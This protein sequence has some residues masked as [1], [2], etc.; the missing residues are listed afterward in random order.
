MD[1]GIYTAFCQVMIVSVPTLVRPIHHYP[2]IQAADH[3]A[4]FTVMFL[5]IQHHIFQH[6]ITTAGI[7]HVAGQILMYP[8][9]SGQYHAIIT[10]LLHGG[11]RTTGHQTGGD[12]AAVQDIID[13]LFH[14]RSVPGE[15]CKGSGGKAAIT[16]IKALFPFH[17]VHQALLGTVMQR[18]H[19]QV[20]NGL[21]SRILHLA[22][23]LEG[24]GIV[25][26]NHGNL[27]QLRPFRT[28]DFCITEGFVIKVIQRVFA[29]GQNPLFF[30]TTIG[31][32]FVA[33]FALFRQFLTIAQGNGVPGLAHGF[34]I[35]ITHI[36]GACI[37][38]ILAGALFA[39]HHRHDLIQNHLLGLLLIQFNPHII[40]QRSSFPGGIVKIRLFKANL[41]A[42]AIVTLQKL[43]SVTGGSQVRVSSVLVPQYRS[44]TLG[45]DLSVTF[46][47]KQQ[48]VTT[49]SAD[50]YTIDQTL[51]I[52]MH[53]NDVFP[54]LQILCDINHIVIVMP[55]VARGGTHGHVMTVDI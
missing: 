26:G 12:L 42:A 39:N 21:Q 45:H 29:A 46:Q 7:L 24:K 50:P 35:Q 52:G 17:A 22:L 55:G 40:P 15:H 32:Q 36:S 37:H 2:L 48:A 18:I 30:I 54:G 25:P 38:K 31:P 4:F 3:A 28:D 47:V 16:Q 43:G 51:I 20:P 11:A 6:I 33:H 14:N 49:I 27:L 34:H 1:A 9:E 23:G 5:K 19:A 41:R 10:D 8:Q 13:Q 53:H 44:V